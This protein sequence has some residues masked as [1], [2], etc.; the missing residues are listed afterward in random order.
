MSD[1]IPTREET[2][3]ASDARVGVVAARFNEPVVNRLFAGATRR[4]AQLGMAGERIETIRVPGA[5][6]LPLA[7]RKMAA[8]ARFD[9]I[10]AL[11]AVIRGDTAHFDFVAGECTRGLGRVMLDFGIPIGF[12]VLTCETQAQA[13]ARSDSTAANKGEQTAL[14]LLQTIAALKQFGQDTQR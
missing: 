5:F 6:E 8:A 2:P 13:L 11:A 12:G 10:L 3:I 14:A 4:L 1:Y 7:A 9:G